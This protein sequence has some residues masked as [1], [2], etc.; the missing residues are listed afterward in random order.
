MILKNIHTS[1]IIFSISTFWAFTIFCPLYVL[2]YF[3]LYLF[4]FYLCFIL[5]FKLMKYY[6]L[7]PLNYYYVSKYMSEYF[8]NTQNNI[9]INQN[10]SLV[11]V[12]PHGIFCVGFCS[13]YHP[14]LYKCISDIL[15][16]SFGFGDFVQTM[17]HTSC[18]KNNMNYMMSNQKNLI[19]LPGGFH[20]IYMIKNYEYNIYIPK[21][22]I[23]L[24]KKHEYT[25]YPVL[26]LGENE[27]FKIFPVS[28]KYYPIL[29]KIIKL[30]PIPFASGL[31]Y[32]IPWVP[33]R[34]PVVTYTG[35]PINCNDFTTI[36]E[37]HEKIKE[38]LTNIFTKNIENYCL[39]CNQKGYSVSP[40]QY[41]I[42]FFD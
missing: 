4:S 24:A 30:V 17:D 13:I 20:D 31:G 19:L 33:F 6:D 37:I 39:L 9:E 21:G 34:I 36:N 29:K 32:I 14:S 18:S 28:S 10:K 11:T 23:N 42:R 3:N 2:I 5:F 7:F 1:F 27:S 16:Y 8:Y 15:L 25:I 41:S 12:F 26:S 40:E 38:E 35:T 22:F